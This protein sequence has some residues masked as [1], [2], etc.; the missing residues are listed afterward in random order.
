MFKKLYQTQN[1]IQII[2]MLF[3]DNIFPL[4][5]DIYLYFIKLIYFYS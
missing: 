4:Q 1:L 5:I 3:E 2:I